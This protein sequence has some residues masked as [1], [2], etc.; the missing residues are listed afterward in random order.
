MTAWQ[1]DAL[2][3]A[4][5]VMKYRNCVSDSCQIRRAMLFVLRLL[6]IHG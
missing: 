5:N 2:H 1:P 3:T 4:A 6:H